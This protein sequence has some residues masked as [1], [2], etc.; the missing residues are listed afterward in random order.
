[1]S[2]LM[3]LGSWL[4]IC[5]QQV[6]TFMA[7][8]D[9]VLVPMW[10][11]RVYVGN[12]CRDISLVS[13]CNWESRTSFWVTAPWQLLCAICILAH[14]FGEAENGSAGFGGTT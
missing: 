9:F 10:L 13:T 14:P 6:P 5:W 4:H 1:M 3:L 2:S 8:C 12:Y 7:S 11:H